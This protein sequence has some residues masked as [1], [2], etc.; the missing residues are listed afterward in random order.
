[1][2]RPMKVLRPS[3][4][5]QSSAM[6]LDILVL[7]IRHK[8]KLSGRRWRIHENAKEYEDSDRFIPLVLRENNPWPSIASCELRH[9]EVIA[10]VRKA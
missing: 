2:I 8:Y 9:N 10:A 3:V 6:D 1:M 5:K 7:I 4:S